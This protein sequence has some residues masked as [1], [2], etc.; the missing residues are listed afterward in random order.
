MDLRVIGLGGKS[1]FGNQLQAQMA[2]SPGAFG[3]VGSL[4]QMSYADAMKTHGSMGS[5][6]GQNRGGAPISD[7]IVGSIGGSL[8]HT[9]QPQY[10]LIDNLHPGQ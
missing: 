6:V 3:P 2:P 1:S 8:T 4:K 10:M 7:A 5:S 9:P